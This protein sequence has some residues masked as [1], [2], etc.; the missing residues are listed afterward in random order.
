VGAQFAAVGTTVIDNSLCLENGSNK[1]TNCTEIN[2]AELTKE[3]KIIA[4]LTALPFKW[5]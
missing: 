1:K 3:D 4:N 2:A 5:F